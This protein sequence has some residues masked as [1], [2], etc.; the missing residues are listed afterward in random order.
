MEKRTTVVL[1][2]VF[3]YATRRCCSHLILFFDKSFTIQS[4]LQCYLYF[5]FFMKKQS[6]SFYCQRRRVGKEVHLVQTQ[7]RMLEPVWSRGTHC[8]TRSTL[9]CLVSDPPCPRPKLSNRGTSSQATLH[10]GKH[11]ASGCGEG[12]S[13]QR[14]HWAAESLGRMETA[15]HSAIGA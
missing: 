7:R 12:T 4:F 13:G 15:G 14:R 3:T 8:A 11:T 9:Q 1:P 10:P 6:D 5:L 2:I